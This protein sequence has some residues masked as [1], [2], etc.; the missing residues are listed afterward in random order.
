MHDP[1]HRSEEELAAALDRIR[2]APRDVGALMMI[3]RRPADAQRE[4]LEEATL[5]PGIGLVGDNWPQ[6]PSK[7]TADGS[8]DPDRQLTIMS[9]R[10]V[11]AVAGARERW[12]LAGDQL[13]VDF[14]LGDAHVPVGTVLAVGRAVLVISPAPH[15][16]C[17]KFTERFGSAASRWIN[18][19][20][21]R[22]L[23][24][25][26]IYARVVVAGVVRRGD[27]IRRR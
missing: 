18:T 21:G 7:H 15:T 16:G 26:G 3:V 11:A 27:S 19:D 25:R 10:A 22:E 20:A 6:R 24:L 14:D 17:A 8:P 4:V 5:E 2:G 13:F 12:P 23:H 1:I 9:S